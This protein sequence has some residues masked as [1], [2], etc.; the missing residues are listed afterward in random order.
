MKVMSSNGRKN[1][2]RTVF[3]G[4]LFFPV[5]P[6][7][8]SLKRKFMDCWS[9]WRDVA[10]KGGRWQWT[11]NPTS[12]ENGSPAKVLLIGGLRRFV[13]CLPLFQAHPWWYTH[14]GWGFPLHARSPSP[15]G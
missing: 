6:S 4:G 15:F 11:A 12:K 5:G 13:P 2:N 1:R 10:P 9:P 7:P 3:I 14:A 8:T